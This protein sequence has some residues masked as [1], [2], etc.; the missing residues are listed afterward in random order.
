MALIADVIQNN[1][2]K[3]SSFQ[4]ATAVN[5]LFQDGLVGSASDQAK[6]ILDA[7]DYGNVQSTLTLGLVDIAWAEQNF[8]DASDTVVASLE[9]VFDEYRVK[10]FYGNQW[11]AIRTIE[12]D[13][14]ASNEPNRLVLEKIGAFWATQVN[15]LIAATVSGMS[16]IAAITTGAVDVNGVHTQDLSR[17]M[18]TTARLQKGDMGFGALAKMYM[19]SA[20]LGDIL[21]KQDAGTI[22]AT[23]ISATYGTVIKVVN[24]IE[25]AVTS[26]TP[27]WVYDGVTP[28]VVDDAMADGI[29]SLIE[30]GA[31]AF[32][33]TELNDPLMY[34]NSPKAGNGAGKEEYGTKALYI[35]HPVGFDFVG[36]LNGAAPAIPFA[37]KSG[38][39]LA[40]LQAGGLYALKVDPKLSPIT[41]LRVKM[42]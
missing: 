17:T 20:T 15:K 25:T 34:A 13:L 22:T 2:W 30:Q 29:I 19:N 21:N 32:T 24:G 42:G 7:M 12:K 35:C 6:A 36:V 4:K 38:L 18:V 5:R 39:S 14:M 28:I 40:E 23:L 33:Q 31:F 8:G 41:N 37:S 10:T 1:N 11:W 27:T 3:S 16:D 26:N 9:G